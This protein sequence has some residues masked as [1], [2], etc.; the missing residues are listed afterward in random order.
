V[1]VTILGESFLYL[2][3]IFR[4]KIQSS[5]I[6]RKDSGNKQLIIKWSMLYLEENWHNNGLL[7]IS[8]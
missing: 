5:T 8:M 3:S 4:T 6:L 7:L 1:V 2:K